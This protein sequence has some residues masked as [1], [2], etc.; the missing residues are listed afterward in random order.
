MTTLQEKWRRELLRR[1]TTLPEELTAE[2]AQAAMEEAFRMAPTPPKSDVRFWHGL[3]EWGAAFSIVDRAI[4][5]L[6]DGGAALAIEAGAFRAP[7][8]EACL[9]DEDALFRD[10]A[11]VRAL[12]LSVPPMEDIP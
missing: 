7:R 1:A 5:D 4:A 3:P 2:E 9:P 12:F 8:R 11:D 6:D 10:L